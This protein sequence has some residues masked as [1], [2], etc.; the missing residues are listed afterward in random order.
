MDVV[1]TQKVSD[2][3]L[4]GGARV[5]D[6]AAGEAYYDAVPQT[7][8]PADIARCAVFALE[9][10]AHMTIAQIVAVPTNEA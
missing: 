5:D 10:P 1:T 8:E 3:E 4:E 9:A 7:L 2:G 6:A